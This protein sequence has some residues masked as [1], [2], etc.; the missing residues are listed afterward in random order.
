[1]S[2]ISIL[3][4]GVPQKVASDQKPTH[5]FADLKD[6][7]VCKINGELRDL[8]SDLNDGDNVESI[9]ISARSSASLKYTHWFS[10]K[11]L[12]NT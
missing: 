4:N 1:M 8:W 2:E 10:S 5:L 9:S 3:V 6:V 12:P 7:V 11:D